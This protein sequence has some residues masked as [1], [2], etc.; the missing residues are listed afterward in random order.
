MTQDGQLDISRDLDNFHWVQYQ[1]YMTG[2]RGGFCD[3]TL[4]EVRIDN[5]YVSEK[6]FCV[7]ASGKA[8]FLRKE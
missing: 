5:E 6:D 2:E 3:A 8:S 7:W 1:L 4:G